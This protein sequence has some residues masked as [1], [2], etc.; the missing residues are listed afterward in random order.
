[1][2]FSSRHAYLFILFSLPMV[3]LAIETAWQR[4]LPGTVQGWGGIFTKNNEKPFYWVV[5]SVVIGLF[6]SW[7]QVFPAYF[8]EKTYPVGAIAYLKEHP[9]DKLILT[10]GKWGSYLIWFTED[11]RGYLDSRFDMYGDRYVRNFISAFELRPGWE[12]F[13]EMTGIEL[14]MY[15]KPSLQVDVLQKI[16]GWNTVYEDDQTIILR[17]KLKPGIPPRQSMGHLQ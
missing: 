12:N 8:N 15:P 17:K 1:M 7:Q 2:L 10:E 9:P 5:L 11:V 13:F 4:Y 16:H 3:V 14:A 6:L